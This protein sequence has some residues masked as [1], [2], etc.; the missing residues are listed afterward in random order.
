MEVIL[1]KLMD[2]ICTIH[3]WNKKQPILTL[4]IGITIG[5]RWEVYIKIYRGH[6]LGVASLGKAPSVVIDIR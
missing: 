2:T 4:V 5:L 3:K 1:V 6:L